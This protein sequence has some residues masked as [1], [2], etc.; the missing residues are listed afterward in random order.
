MIVVYEIVLKT[1]VCMYLC[2]VSMIMYVCCWYPN[3]FSWSTYI[4]FASLLPYVSHSTIHLDQ[5][6]CFH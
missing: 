4:T 3:D 1:I 5:E 6:G 2:I